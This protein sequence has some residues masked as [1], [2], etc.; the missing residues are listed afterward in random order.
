MLAH[1]CKADITKVVFEDASR[2][3]RG[4]LVQECAYEKLTTL[5]L[6]LISATS[7][8]QFLSDTI[9]ARMLRQILGAVCEFERSTMVQRLKHAREQK[10]KT[11]RARTLHG[12]PKVTGKKSR[13]EGSDG[14]HIKTALRRWVG[15]PILALGDT[16]KAQ[17]A[18]S[19]CGIKTN[20]GKDMSNAQVGTW[21]RALR[22]K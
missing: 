2:L 20:T 5:G 8:H 16:A 14:A 17:K 3:A 15:K 1:M 13:L 4:L 22:A 19:A 18:L 10:Q 11:T 7:P 9:S 6:Q 21:L 12:K